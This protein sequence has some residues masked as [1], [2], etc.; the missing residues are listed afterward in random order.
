M[1]K[2]FTLILLFSFLSNLYAEKYLSSASFTPQS[3]IGYYSLY[4]YTY[5]DVTIHMIPN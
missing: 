4:P 2:I 1:K 5:Q 3:E